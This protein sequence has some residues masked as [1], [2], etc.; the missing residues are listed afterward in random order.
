[1]NHKKYQ[2]KDIQSTKEVIVDQMEVT[3]L[4]R[5]FVDEMPKVHEN[6]NYHRGEMVDPEVSIST[7]SHSERSKL[8]KRTK[9]EQKGKIHGVVKITKYMSDKE[10]VSS[11]SF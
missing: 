5:E 4:M 11:E 9:E 1:M 6:V 7:K 10:K 3:E 2:K 8:H